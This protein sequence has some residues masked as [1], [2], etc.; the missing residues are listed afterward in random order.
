MSPDG[1][2][3]N[4]KHTNIL[5]ASFGLINSSGRMVLK[6]GANTR[7]VNEIR[8]KD[9]ALQLT[10]ECQCVVQSLIDDLTSKPLLQSYSMDKEVA[11]TTD[12]S[13][14]TIDGVLA[15]IGAMYFM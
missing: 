9:K 8:Q 11:L 3:P 5:E 15:E 4:P 1:V 7:C 2:K 6:L 12:A 14:I 10:D 13:K